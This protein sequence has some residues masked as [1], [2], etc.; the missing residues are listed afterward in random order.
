MREGREETE[1]YRAR[2]GKCVLVKMRNFALK[3]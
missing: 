2:V 3:L 1:K